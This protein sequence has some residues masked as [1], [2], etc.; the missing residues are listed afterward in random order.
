MKISAAK[1]KTDLLATL[2]Y[3]LNFDRSFFQF[4]QERY[5]LDFDRHLYNSCEGK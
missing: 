3:S 2:Q 4:S 1:Q 5:K